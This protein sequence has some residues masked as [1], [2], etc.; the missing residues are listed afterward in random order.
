M[1]NLNDKPYPYYTR[2]SYTKE[3]EKKNVYVKIPNITEQETAELNMFLQ[4]HFNKYRIDNDVERL[5]VCELLDQSMVK[6]FILYNGNV[7]TIKMYNL[8][9]PIVNSVM[10]KVEVVNVVQIENACLDELDKIK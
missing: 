2:K 4:A 8:F 7:N 3:D 1:T 5:I 9:E 10:S 6:L